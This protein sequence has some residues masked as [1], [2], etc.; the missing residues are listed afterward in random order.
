MPEFGKIEL[1]LIIGGIVLAGLG[2]QW[3]INILIS[4][5][6]F[7]LG[8]GLLIGGINA[9]L[10]PN[11]GFWH[12]DKINEWLRGVI[13][14]IWGV[15]WV[16]GGLWALLIALVIL[17]GKGEIAQ[18]YIFR[19]PGILILSIGIALL[20]KGIT[21]MFEPMGDSSS[22]G[23]ILQRLPSRIGG[24]LLVLLSI[25]LIVLGLF[26]T[27]TPIGFDA[28]ISSMFNIFSTGIQ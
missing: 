17:L 28:L 14:W 1:S 5:G 22:I 15:I 2:S 18:A 27:F 12:H 16:L 24:F 4:L 11:F 9:L 19:H 7:L 20:G 23:E 10:R 26:E 25:A 3:T 21:N 8:T 13:L 6:V